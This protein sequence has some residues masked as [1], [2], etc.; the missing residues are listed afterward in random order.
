MSLL[1][2][3]ILMSFSVYSDV[4]NRGIYIVSK[5]FINQQEVEGLFF[6]GFRTTVFR[7]LSVDMTLLIKCK[8]LIIILLSASV[9]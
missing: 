1:H 5:T 3:T 2:Y 9:K 6:H 8:E 4:L 7:S